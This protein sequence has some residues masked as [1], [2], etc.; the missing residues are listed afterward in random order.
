MNLFHYVD[1]YFVGYHIK[2]ANHTLRQLKQ[3]T[4]T[5]RGGG[6]STAATTT[7]TT[8]TATTTTNTATT[9]TTTNT[10]TTTTTT[11]TTTTAALCLICLRLSFTAHRTG[12]LQRA[13]NRDLLFALSFPLSRT[14]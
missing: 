10:A 12:Y 7:T 14:E 3:I 13:L 8:N 9:T 2:C 1:W 5:I 4:T 6:D 11:T